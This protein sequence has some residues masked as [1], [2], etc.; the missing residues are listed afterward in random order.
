M[1]DEKVDDKLCAT[2]C[3][4]KM[5]NFKENN[6]Y[7]DCKYFKHLLKNKMP[8]EVVTKYMEDVFRNAFRNN[9]TYKVHICLKGV[10]I[11]DCDRYKNF[12][13]EIS[14]KLYY[15]CENDPDNAL[16]NL[17]VYNPSTIISALHRIF[18]ML[19]HVD[20][21]KKIIMVK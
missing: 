15:L 4:E 6:I 18:D 8:L 7:V 10:S 19:C 5:C 16:Q 21:K 20:I 2:V 12:A 3:L 14:Y 9:S 11:T 13:K 1:F 17:Y